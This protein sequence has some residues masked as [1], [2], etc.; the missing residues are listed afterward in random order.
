M[1]SLEIAGKEKKKVE[2][3]AMSTLKQIEIVVE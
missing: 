2:E 1:D 3:L